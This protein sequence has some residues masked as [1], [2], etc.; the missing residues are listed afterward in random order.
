MHIFV[1]QTREDHG[2][3]VTGVFFGSSFWGFQS[4]LFFLWETVGH[5]SILQPF[6]FTSWNEN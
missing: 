4:I 6:L 5:E 2:L 1:V 3:Q